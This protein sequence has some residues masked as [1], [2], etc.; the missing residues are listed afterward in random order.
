[1]SEKDKE[2]TAFSTA[3]GLY[4]FNVMSFGLCN[5]LATFKRSMERV[6]VG[7][8]WQVLLC[9]WRWREY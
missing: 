4:Q 5:A 9:E 3:S 2:K 7:L 6:L 8:P 1:M